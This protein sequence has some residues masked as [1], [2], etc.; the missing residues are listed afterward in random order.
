MDNSGE[1]RLDP[2]VIDNGIKNQKPLSDLYE[3]PVFAVDTNQNAWERQ[4][5]KKARLEHIRRNVFEADGQAK[6]ERLEKIYSQIFRI[7]PMRVNYETVQGTSDPKGFEETGAAKPWP[8]PGV[9]AVG[10]VVLVLVYQEKR[11]KKVCLRGK[12]F[13]KGRSRGNDSD[14]YGG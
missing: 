9:M 11:Q 5:E 6:E 14:V 1:I 10:F 2:D 7:T 8:L 13:T 3:L 12:A 4:K